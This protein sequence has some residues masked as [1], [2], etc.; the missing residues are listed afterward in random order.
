M[1]ETA[2]RRPRLPPAWFMHTFWRVHRALC[3]LSGG[4]F[5][6]TPASKRGW[7]PLR[8]TTVGRTAWRP[9]HRKNL[10]L[11]LASTKV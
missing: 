2:T 3:Q 1:S 5:L 10:G 8:L 9:L 7:G 4:R 6:W 11:S